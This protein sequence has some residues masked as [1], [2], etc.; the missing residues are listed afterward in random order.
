MLRAIERAT[1]QP[2]EPMAL[3][4]VG[5][6]EA[7]RL[8]RFQA[9]IKAA[10]EGDELEAG[11]EMVRQTL[12][13]LAVSIEDLAAALAL[14][15]RGNARRLLDEREPVADSGSE[16][17]RAP[18]EQRGQGAP[19]R[20]DTAP[21]T[22]GNDDLVSYRIEVG[23][24]HGV[25]PG[26][27][28]GAIANEAG[29]DSGQIGRINIQQGFSIVDLP[30]SLAAETLE[31]LRGVRVAGQPLLIRLDTG[32]S[33]PAAPNPKRPAGK[34]APK[35]KPGRQERKKPRD[36]GG[37]DAGKKPDKPDRPARA[38][39]ARTR[40]ERKAQFKSRKKP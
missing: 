13:A 2:I 23:A 32:A 28:V 37:R 29:L 35:N 4:T 3:P 38:R 31:H 21:R 22:K 20:R 30:A 26:N 11:R 34:P 12:D 36:A 39:P 6:V 14:I 27:I 15:A 10:L 19:S 33:G 8:V 5:D 24:G 7:Q 18:R 1:R 17:G 9:K 16:A 40:A 25:K